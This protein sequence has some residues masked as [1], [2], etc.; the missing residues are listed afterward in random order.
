M[1]KKLKYS[2]K[3]NLIKTN[4]KKMIKLLKM[5]IKRILIISSNKINKKIYKNLRYFNKLSLIIKMKTNQR[6]FNKTIIIKNKFY[7][8]NQVK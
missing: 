1:K 7:N 6:I 8:K 5:K 3:T 2:K 4:K